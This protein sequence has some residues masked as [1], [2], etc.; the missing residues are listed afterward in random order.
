MVKKAGKKS[1]ATA[2]K[3]STRGAL[4]IKRAQVATP[5]VSQPPVAAVMSKK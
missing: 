4:P 5:V 3:S 2:N 1:A